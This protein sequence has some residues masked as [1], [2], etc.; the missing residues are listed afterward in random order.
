YLLYLTPRILTLKKNQVQIKMTWI[1]LASCILIG[2]ISPYY[3]DHYYHPLFAFTF[4][5]PA[6]YYSALKGEGNY[7]TVFVIVALI[8]MWT[9]GDTYSPKL[10]FKIEP[11]TEDHLV[12]RLKSEPDAS[13]FVDY[14]EASSYYIRS[15]KAHHAFLPVGLWIHF[16]EHEMGEKNRE[17][18]WKDLSE[19]PA[20]YLLTTYTTAR[21]SWS[22]PDTKF[23]ENH[24]EKVDSLKREGKLDLYLWKLK[25]NRAD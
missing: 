13:L 21:F 14:V 1:L 2:L 18:I 19:N 3:F 8:S 5:L 7:K 17:Q 4:I 25:N 22:L 23:Y 9:I 24:Y 6:V 15:E 10:K 16:G 12:K 20:T 11:Y